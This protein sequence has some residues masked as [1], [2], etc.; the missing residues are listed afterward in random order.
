M[1]NA[2]QFPSFANTSERRDQ[3]DRQDGRKRAK[4]DDSNF[5]MKIIIQAHL[6]LLTQRRQPLAMADRKKPGGP[7]RR[8]PG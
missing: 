2:A 6:P 8:P 4:G 3:P 1:R 7:W 5:Q